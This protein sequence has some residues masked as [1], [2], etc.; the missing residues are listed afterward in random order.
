MGL[1]RIYAVLWL[2]AVRTKRLSWNLVDYSAS[3]FLWAAI[4]TLMLLAIFG[5]ELGARLSVVVIPWLYYTVGLATTAG[6]INYYVASGMPDYELH[7]GHNPVATVAGRIVTSAAAA[8]PPAI[9]AALALEALGA[10]PDPALLA[11]S[12]A[13]ALLVGHSYGLL[14]TALGASQG[15][16]GSMLDILGYASGLFGGLLIPLYYFPPWLRAAAL[17]TPLA[18]L[19]ELAR[20]SVPGNPLVLDAGHALAYTAA[21]IAALYAAAALAAKGFESRARRTGIRITRY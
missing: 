15:V 9:A 3:M 2:H 6:W 8:T 16:P 17:A 4:N 1:R 21:W 7:L 12:A 13:L 19:G 14:L 10:H 5:V 20:A 11:A 18:P